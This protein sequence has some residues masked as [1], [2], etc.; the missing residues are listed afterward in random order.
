M[1][2]VCDACVSWKRF[3]AKCWFYWENKKTCSQ[4]VAN[5]FS[6]PQFKSVSEEVVWR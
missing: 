5:E 3:G 6:E 1:T 4:F 2:R